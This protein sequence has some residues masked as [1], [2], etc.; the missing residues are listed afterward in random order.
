MRIRI[1]SNGIA[2]DQATGR[3]LG[4]VISQPLSRFSPGRNIDLEIELPNTHC[5]VGGPDPTTGQ[6][7]C[8]T[9]PRNL[10][11][12]RPDEDRVHEV[13]R[14]IRAQLDQV[15]VLRIGGHAEPFWEDR[16]F[17]LLSE[18]EL[19]PDH[20]PKIV[21]ITNG[22]LL[23]EERATRWFD[24]V[25][26]SQVSFSVDAA[27]PHTYFRLRRIAE[28]E[29]VVRNVDEYCRRR[30]PE[31]HVA[32]I[33]NQINL[34][35]IDEIESMV[36]MTQDHF[37]HYLTLTPTKPYKKSLREICLNPANRVQFVDARQRA[38]SVA[39]SLGVNLVFTDDWPA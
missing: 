9:C 22:T 15:A 24:S 28:F 4:N 36:R 6:R 29:R 5:N 10:D 26:H 25:G 17:E 39:A 33:R 18:L 38:E 3:R 7:A 30:D 19:D 13:C 23:N 32:A 21:T 35:N 1:Q 31:R 16:I 12:F 11:R 2:L 27:S 34:L 14:A 37:L 8:L 20:A